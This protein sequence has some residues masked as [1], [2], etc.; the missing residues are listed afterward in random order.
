MSDQSIRNLLA[1]SLAVMYAILVTFAIVT[2]LP[3][4]EVFQGVRAELFLE[5]DRGVVYSRI[6]SVL[7]VS[8]LTIVTTL[9]FLRTVP[10]LFRGL[11]GASA[12]LT[13]GSTIILLSDFGNDDFQLERSVMYI[14]VLFSFSALHVVAERVLGDGGS[15]ADHSADHPSSS[16]RS[17]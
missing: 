16:H 9:G 6:A 10:E 13:V 12:L 15:S 2:I 8:I 1:F 4:K 3:D 11:I 14:L 5:A 17:K 7:V